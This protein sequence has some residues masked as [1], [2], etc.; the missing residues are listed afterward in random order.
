MKKQIK[1]EVSKQELLS[2][3]IEIRDLCAN[4]SQEDQQ[5]DP[6]ALQATLEEVFVL[7]SELIPRGAEPSWYTTG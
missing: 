7:T 5:V 1:S 4:Y 6:T 3:L 2:V